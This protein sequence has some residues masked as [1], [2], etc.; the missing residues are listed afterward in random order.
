VCKRDQ[1][2][3]KQGIPDTRKCL[4]SL[5]GSFGWQR[6]VSKLLTVREVAEIIETTPNRVSSSMDR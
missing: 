1:G 5:F 4:F 3:N 2:K 6:I